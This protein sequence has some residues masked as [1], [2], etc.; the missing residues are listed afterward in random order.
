MF[1][2]QTALEEEIVS[3]SGAEEDLFTVGIIQSMS[4]CGAQAGQVLLA[5]SFK[6]GGGVSSKLSVSAVT[7]THCVCFIHWDGARYPHGTRGWVEQSKKLRG[8]SC[9]E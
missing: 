2:K 5:V 3:S 9:A 7:Q 4:P 1:A 8:S 6:T